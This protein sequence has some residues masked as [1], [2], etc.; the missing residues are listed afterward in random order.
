MFDEHHVDSDD[1]FQVEPEPT[2]DQVLKE[3]RG[4]EDL[5]PY[6]QR[7][8]ELEK[9]KKKGG[10]QGAQAKPSN[11]RYCTDFDLSGCSCCPTYRA[12]HHQQGETKQKAKDLC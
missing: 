8:Q 12:T 11:T 5:P 3:G 2:L 7:L 6:M 9:S 10:G 4:R 1:N